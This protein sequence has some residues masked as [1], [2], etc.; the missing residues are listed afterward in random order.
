M[1]HFWWDDFCDW[2]LELKKLESDWSYAYIVYEKALRLLHPVMPFLTEELWHRLEMPGG[3]LSRLLA[4]YPQYEATAVN[5]DAQHAVAVIQ[6]VVTEIRQ[7]RAAEKIDKSQ[8][9]KAEVSAPVSAFA[10]LEAN[11]SAVERLASVKLSLANGT[12]SPYAL[13][14][15]IPVD[16][17]RLEKQN[18]E[19]GKQILQTWIVNST[20][21]DF[22][23]K[24]PEKVIA[25]MRSKKAEYEAQIAKNR[26]AL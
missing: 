11:R 4:K 5:P 7:H 13:K 22:M 24:A 14:L 6:R 25:G 21:P 20:V 12:Q 17:A 10:I 23:A 2:Y 26:A 18:A 16:C 9:L 8:V 19:L 3:S 1:W 15:D